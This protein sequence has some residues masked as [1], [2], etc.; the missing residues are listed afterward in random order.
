MNITEK[1]ILV[2]LYQ[3][4][5]KHSGYQ[6]LPKALKTLIHEDVKQFI[7]RFEQER[8]DWLLSQID[9]SGKRVLD[10]GGNTGFFTF[11]AIEAGAK[12]VIYVEGNPNHSD[13]VSKA[14]DILGF[15][16]DVRNKY[17]DFYSDLKND[18]IDIVLLFNVIHHLGDDFGDQGSS[19][20]EALEKMKEAINYFSDKTNI[21]VLQMG[22]CWKGD[23]N[24][25]LFKNGTKSEMIDFVKSAT[26]EK[27]EIQSIGIPEEKDGKTE[28]RELSL[29]NI[30]RFD[31]LGEFRNRPIFILKSK[32]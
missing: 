21:M 6:I 23:R 5:S 14:K 11:E 16:I 13:F 26:I 19:K 17:F 28:Y 8:L 12:E 31:S 3:K 9:F 32:G 15:N 10:I 25:L 4:N 7:S 20:E 1:D 22:F 2:D 18:R 29:Q 24:E 27:W 30:E